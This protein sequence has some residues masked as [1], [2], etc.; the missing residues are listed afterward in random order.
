MSR[1]PWGAL[2]EDAR[3]VV[4]RCVEIA[5]EGA[6]RELS[7]AVFDMA[8]DLA[9]VVGGRDA[10]LHA[11]ELF[12]RIRVAIEQTSR[13][14][15]EDDEASALGGLL[16]Q[17]ARELDDVLD[18][19]LAAM[20][21]AT[22]PPRPP[23]SFA[24]SVTSPALHRLPPQRWT[25]ILRRADGPPQD[26][27]AALVREQ[28]AQALELLRVDLWLRTPDELHPWS[29]AVA[30][31][32]ER[33]LC[34]LDLLAALA[35]VGQDDG[36]ELPTALGQLLS[37]PALRGQRIA[38]ACFV[39]GCIDDEHALR[40]IRL[41]LR[42][43]EE[44]DHQSATFA[45]ALASNPDVI[46]L[47]EELLLEDDHAL[48]TLALD[49]LYMRGASHV[50]TAGPF[51]AHPSP[52]VRA[53]A[54]RAL[55]GEPRGEGGAI[56][57]LESALYDEPN[58]RVIA[59]LIES[60]LRHGHRRAL[61]ELRRRLDQEG[62]VPNT[63]SFTHKVA[64]M[65]MLS[66]AGDAADLPRLLRLVGEP[67]TLLALG[68]YGHVKALAPLLALLRAAEEAFLDD[69]ALAAATAL[70]RITGALRLDDG[71]VCLEA[72]PW[73]RWCRAHTTT[74]PPDVRMRFGA[75][76]TVEA[77]LEEHMSPEGAPLREL[78]MEIAFLTAV[79]LRAHD[80]VH[81]QRRAIDAT[82]NATRLHSD[83][84]SWPAHRIGRWTRSADGGQGHG[85]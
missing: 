36:I 78:E 14:A 77:A 67:E 72:G 80:W 82:A 43:L 32:E 54:A 7:H 70:Y 68:W 12:D 20:A 5:A 51:L 17:L 6:S 38:A 64:L 55:S 29:P 11:S 76:H 85:A 4:E 28:A 66:V 30:V 22:P 24:A 83:P 58:Q 63:L 52:M 21:A 9:E 49:V 56:A 73:E 23:T 53:A 62:E 50:G 60:L 1:P 37:S 42:R 8:E 34:Q 84:G 19:V 79:Q 33:A 3:A 35:S 41:L 74:W 18:S 26:A 15:A 10:H 69:L 71:S 39:L 65:R 13:L 44:N 40:M 25:Y 57:L 16:S 48:V 31:F 46:P 61:D 27:V 75:P 2:L 47:M 81:A 59:A 45:L